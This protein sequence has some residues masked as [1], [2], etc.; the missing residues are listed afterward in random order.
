MMQELTGGAPS[1][2]YQILGVNATSLE[3]G[4]AGMVA[5]RVLPWLQDVSA[6][7]AWG[8]W[9]VTERDVRVLDRENHLLFVYNL[10]PANHDLS[11]PADYAE[12]KQLL[13][14]AAAGLILPP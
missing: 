10:N 6:V 3:S 12:L 13:Q 4:N 7:D 11:D 14:D 8:D 5:G 1:T 9:G 2:D